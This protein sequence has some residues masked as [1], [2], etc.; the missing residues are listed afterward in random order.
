VIKN[1]RLVT[2]QKIQPIIQR[3]SRTIL[4]F[5]YP[6]IFLLAIFSF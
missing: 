1:D 4:L 2:T 3:I 5:F 6:T